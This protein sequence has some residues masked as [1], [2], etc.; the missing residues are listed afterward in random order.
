MRPFRRHGQKRTTILAKMPHSFAEK[1]LMP[2]FEELNN[3]LLKHLD[4]AAE[5]IIAVAISKDLAE[6]KESQ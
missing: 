2:E 1:T 6:P 5:Q 4:E 3:V